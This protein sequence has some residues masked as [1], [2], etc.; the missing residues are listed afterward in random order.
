MPSRL[1]LSLR[2]P[3]FMM[4][5]TLGSVSESEEEI[6]STSSIIIDVIPRIF[7]GV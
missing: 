1:L 3:K 5:I 2:V 7:K 4:E 6:Y